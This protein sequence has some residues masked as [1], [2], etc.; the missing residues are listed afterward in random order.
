MNSKDQKESLFAEFNE[1]AERGRRIVLEMADAKAYDVPEIKAISAFAIWQ[2]MQHPDQT[3]RV[4]AVRMAIEA[5]YKL[6]NALIKSV[7]LKFLV[8]E[9]IT[10]R[11]E[12]NDLLF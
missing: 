6:S 5:A 1:S 12:E 7:P 8:S 9:S 3:V 10:S 4:Q 2:G 11:K